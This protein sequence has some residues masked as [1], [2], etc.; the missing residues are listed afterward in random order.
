MCQSIIIYREMQILRIN[1]GHR[2]IASVTSSLIMFRARHAASRIAFFLFFSIL[3]LYS[4]A[5][6]RGKIGLPVTVRLCP[7]FL[8]ISR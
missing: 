6:W 4:A 7:S 5:F 8:S 2:I 1:A 3:I